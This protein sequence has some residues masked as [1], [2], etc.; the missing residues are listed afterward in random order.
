M[1]LLKQNPPISF[2]KF[3]QLDPFEVYKTWFESSDRQLLAKEQQMQDNMLAI[4]YR[5]K[6]RKLLAKPE[7][8]NLNE[9]P[10]GLVATLHHTKE[11]HV[12]L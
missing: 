7:P 6:S 9:I 4:Q 5:S 1:T 8:L 2:H 3:W 12:D 10:V 11:R